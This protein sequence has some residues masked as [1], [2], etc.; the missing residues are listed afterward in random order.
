ML[1]KIKSMMEEKGNLLQKVSNFNDELTKKVEMATE[2]LELRNKELQK[3]NATLFETQRRAK[4]LE[5]LSALAYLVATVAHEI[6][7]PLQSVSG[8]IQLLLDDKSVNHEIRKK[9]ALVGSQIER[10]VMILQ[11]LLLNTRQP[12]LKIQKIDLNDLLEELLSLVK[13][14]T[15]LRKINLVSNLKSGLP[16]INGDRAQ[17]Y[18]VFL[19]LLTNAMDSMPEGGDLYIGTSLEGLR[20]SL[21]TSGQ[22]HIKII[23]KQEDTRVYWKTRE[24]QGEEF[25]TVSIKDTGPGISAETQEKI[26][27][28]FFTTKEFGKGSGLGLAISKQIIKSHKG[29][30]EVDSA[31]GVG[32]SFT[33][34]LPV[35]S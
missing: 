5:R 18:Q 13:P 4:K 29:I 21:D 12:E 7:T 30:I 22:S 15:V 8:H 35:S 2:E 31:M 9:L 14:G 6:G 3:A 1:G 19:N 27:E 20:S 34:K 32:T 25:I 11:D 23:Q 24:R 10:T 33:I 17:L 26:F 16:S 28:P